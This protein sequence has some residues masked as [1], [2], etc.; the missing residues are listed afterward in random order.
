[1]LYYQPNKITKKMDL[2]KKRQELEALKAK[3]GVDASAPVPH[4]QKK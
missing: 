2:D 1:V 4:Y 3:H